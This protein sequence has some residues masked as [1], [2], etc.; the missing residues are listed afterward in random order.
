MSQDWS[1]SLTKHQE[2][3]GSIMKVEGGGGRKLGWNDNFIYLNV[4]WMELTPRSLVP[5]ATLQSKVL[6][7]QL[8]Q[9]TAASQKHWPMAVLRCLLFYALL[10]ILYSQGSIAW[11]LENV[12]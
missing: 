10:L 1:T 6:P 12:W 5:L 8:A 11:S 2:G 4:S 9:D 7:I 3:S